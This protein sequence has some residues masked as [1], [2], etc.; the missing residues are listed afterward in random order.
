MS[1][2]PMTFS[3]PRLAALDGF[4]VEIDGEGA[5]RYRPRSASV[6]IVFP[7]RS[8]ISSVGFSRR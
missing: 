7:W 4:R 8:A 1:S 3:D 6:Q 5:R 2:Q